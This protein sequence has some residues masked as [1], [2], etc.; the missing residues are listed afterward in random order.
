M[1]CSLPLLSNIEHVRA[2]HYLIEFKTDIVSRIIN[3]RVVIFFDTTSKCELQ[4]QFCKDHCNNCRF[5]SSHLK[6]KKFPIVLEC[7]NMKINNL[8]ELK[9]RPDQN[10]KEL[11]Q[12]KSYS[13]YKNKYDTFDDW[14]NNEK[15]DLHFTQNEWSITIQNEDL[16][17]SSQFPMVIC[18]DYSTDPNGDSLYW[19][20]I[21]S[22]ICCFTSGSS[23]NNRSLIPSQDRPLAM[24]TWQAWI[25]VPEDYFVSMTG[26]NE[27]L[28]RKETSSHDSSSSSL[29]N[30]KAPNI[31]K[32]SYYYTS[33][34]LPMS[35]L[36]ISI[37]NWEKDHIISSVESETYNKNFKK[38]ELENINCNHIPYPCHIK[39]DS[40]LNGP[41]I[42]V[43]VVSSKNYLSKRK[44]ILKF[45][46]FI[47]IA[48]YK[49]LGIHPFRRLEIV[50][51]PRCFPHLGLAS[52]NLLFLS[53]SIIYD[54]SSFYL[55]LAHEISHNWSGITI[56]PKN[57]EEEW[58]SEG[59]ATYLEDSLFMLALE[60]DQDRKKESIEGGTVLD[61]QSE[62]FN[63]RSHIKYKIL[64]DEKNN[65]EEGLQILCPDHLSPSVGDGSI[66]NGINHSKPFLQVHYLKGYF[67]LLYLSRKVSRHHFDLFLGKVAIK[68][69]GQLISSGEYLQLFFQ[70]F[71]EVNIGE[72]PVDKIINEWLKT[73]DLN[74]HITD[75]FKSM[76]NDEL[77]EVINKHYE[78]WIN[79]NNSI[80]I[81][82]QNQGL[83]GKSLKT[84]LV[85]YKLSFSDQ[86][87][88]LFE[89][90][91]QY[92][93]LKACTLKGIKSFYNV[94][95]QNPE[96]QHR[97]CE[98][99]VRF[100]Y[101]EIDDIMHFL[102][103]NQALGVY[104][105]GELMIS[106]KKKHKKLAKDIFS[107]LKPELST[108]SKAVISSML[109]GE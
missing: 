55:R 99:I 9:P 70:N 19:R 84:E 27:P 33:M 60:E 94:E 46:K 6:D 77:T 69:H 18:I 66:N 68:C 45:I 108:N 14:V 63:L 79:Y 7:C 28:I 59:F 81:R 30:T 103:E 102:I 74:T 101:P 13:N 58:I 43:T 89:R 87:I 12:L 15:T 39:R 62:F 95:N 61:K 31:L 83:E 72:D 92:N 73:S 107:F 41:L 80:S 23:I 90:F 67:L 32:T 8:Q 35:T 105:Y 64:L 2:R 85:N 106:K 17:N 3:G 56:G 26:D 49:L 1:D 75:S 51:L 65:T 104:L 47:L 91:L 29:Y 57:W 34:V 16:F 5:D 71:P 20:K 54:D 100:D 25:T 48:A 42:P 50:I 24:A 44:I 97:W 53:K 88:V 38:L 78:Y 109:F 4:G 37:G 96:V 21:E 93:S 86:I 76:A 82:K 36:A 98:L 22:S 52:P 10:V 40:N 11:F